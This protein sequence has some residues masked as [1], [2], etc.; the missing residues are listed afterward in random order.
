MIKLHNVSLVNKAYT[1]EWLNNISKRG[2]SLETIKFYN[3]FIFRK[4]RED[5]E[6]EEYK[7]E[8]F[9]KDSMFSSMPSGDVKDFDRLSKTFGLQRIKSVG[10]V[11]VFK[12]LDKENYK[13]LYGI[14]E[15][16]SVVKKILKT[17]KIVL[18]MPFFL[19]MLSGIF[20][21][22]DN[23]MENNW[24]INDIS[25]TIMLMAF[26]C[27][28]LAQYSNMRAF[29][30]INK[31]NF[32]NPGSRIIYLNNK[33]RYNVENYFVFILVISATVSIIATIWH[34][35]HSKNFMIFIATVFITLFMSMAFSI[36]FTKKIRPNINISEKRK[37]YI[38]I[39]GLAAITVF[40][41]IF[42]L[43]IVSRV[44]A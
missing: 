4:R 36:F 1:E 41:I 3:L 17:L 28:F 15:E 42:V 22:I 24:E 34:M 5:E 33:V 13:P 6:L 40:N 8:V 32:L 14:E 43:S 11:G 27:F 30:R 18:F 16:K 31:E 39:I 21:T 25:H 9:N 10:Q 7:L 26:L 38:F 35:T 2:Y 20:Q 37:K 12:V 19:I 23:I 29:D 44:I